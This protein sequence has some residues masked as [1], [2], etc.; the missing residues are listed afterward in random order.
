MKRTLSI[1]VLTMTFSAGIASAQSSCLMTM[2]QQRQMILSEGPR[3]LQG[4]GS[5]CFERLLKG[6]MDLLKKAGASNADDRLSV[7]Q[8]LLASTMKAEIFE[9]GSPE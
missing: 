1:L 4:R 5:E 2:A 7:I 9:N 3:A 8:D 6:Q